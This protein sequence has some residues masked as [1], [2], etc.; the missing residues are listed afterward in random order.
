MAVRG[1]VVDKNGNPMA[2]VRVQTEQKVNGQM[3]ALM[4][5]TNSSGDY[6]FYFGQPTQ[7]EIYAIGSDG[8]SS[9][10]SFS[11]IDR[12]ITVPNLIYSRYGE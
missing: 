3:G 2:G 12:D 7:G 4:V 8:I 1:K 9:K 6:V 11:A 10:M 5:K